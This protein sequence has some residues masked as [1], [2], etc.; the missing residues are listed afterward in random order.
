M[1]GKNEIM[2]IITGK[3]HHNKANILA[4]LRI[5]HKPLAMIYWNIPIAK[6]IKPMFENPIVTIPKMPKAAH[7]ANHNAMRETPS[8]LSMDAI[9]PPFQLYLNLKGCQ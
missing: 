8:G 2:D 6:T 4:H 7:R 5:D 1:I 3:L 9:S